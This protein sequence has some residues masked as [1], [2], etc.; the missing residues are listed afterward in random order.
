MMFP[1][2]NF[3]FNCNTPVPLSSAHWAH[4]CCMTLGTR[5]HIILGLS[6]YI[7]DSSSARSLPLLFFYP[8]CKVAVPGAELGPSG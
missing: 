1:F 8:Q 3:V 4:L 5:F 6:C 7:A 2:L